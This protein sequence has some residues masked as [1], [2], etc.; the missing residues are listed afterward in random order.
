MRLPQALVRFRSDG[1][2]G[3]GSH[4]E[5]YAVTRGDLNN[6]AVTVGRALKTS[7]TGMAR[8]ETA[9]SAGALSQ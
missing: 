9:T 5:S 4:R 1:W 7:E 3:I 6:N 2:E 8:Y